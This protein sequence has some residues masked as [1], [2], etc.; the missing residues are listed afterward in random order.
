MWIFLGR[1]KVNENNLPEIKINVIKLLRKLVPSINKTANYFPRWRR[2]FYMLL[3][4]HIISSEHLV[5]KQIIKSFTGLGCPALW[6]TELLLVGTQEVNL[7]ERRIVHS[8]QTHPTRGGGGWMERGETTEDT[9]RNNETHW[10]ASQAS[11]WLAKSITNEMCFGRWAHSF[12][13]IVLCTTNWVAQN[14]RD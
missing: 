5:E 2:C 4:P 14:K 6:N 13:N 9:K 3:L 10:Q 8:C 12:P 7:Y 1:E 11:K